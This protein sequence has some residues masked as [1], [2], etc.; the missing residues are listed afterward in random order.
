LTAK[1]TNREKLLNYC[2]IIMGETSLLK[3]SNVE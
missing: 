2:P 3:A 1:S